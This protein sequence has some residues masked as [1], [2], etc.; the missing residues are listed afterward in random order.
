MNH[1]RKEEE[2]LARQ[3]QGS[4]ARTPYKSVGAAASVKGGKRL[5]SGQRLPPGASANRQRS[6]T[7]SIY[8]KE[9]H[10]GSAPTNKHGVRLQ[11]TRIDPSRFDRANAAALAK[12]PKG[13]PVVDEYYL[14]QRIMQLNLDR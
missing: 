5:I 13:G 14:N 1:D 12:V 9:S 10:L 2:Y 8:E 3:P 11:S 6:P 4:E 7:Q